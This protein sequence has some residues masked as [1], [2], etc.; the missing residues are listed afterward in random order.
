MTG[1]ANNQYEV[2]NPWADA[3]SKPKRGITPRLTDLKGKTIGLFENQKVSAKPILN[4]VKN[5]LKERYPTCKFSWFA[6]PQDIGPVSGPPKQLDDSE[7]KG[8]FEE[9]LKGVDAV[10]AAVGD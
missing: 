9:W 7:H 2:L 5:Q 4:A 6:S 10:V 3:E 8:E 1:S